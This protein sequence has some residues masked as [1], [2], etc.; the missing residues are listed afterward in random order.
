MRSRFESWFDSTSEGV[1]GSIG[2]S[3]VLCRGFTRCPSVRSI[4]YSIKAIQSRLGSFHSLLSRCSTSTSGRR[5]LPR[6]AA[7]RRFALGNL[8]STER[9]HVRPCRVGPRQRTLFG[10]VIRHIKVREKITLEA[11]VTVTRIARS[12]RQ[13]RR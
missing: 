7:E 8:I 3:R 5:V 10:E 4:L 1:R 9:S 11:A 12:W 13:R 2:K 6:P